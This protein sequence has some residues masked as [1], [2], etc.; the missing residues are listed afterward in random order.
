MLFPSNQLFLD[1]RQK[2]LESMQIIKQKVK[3]GKID[4]VIDDRNLHIKDLFSKE[5][6]LK[7]FNGL[8]VKLTE[9]GTWGKIEGL[10]G[11]SGKIKV[12]MEEPI[13]ADL[14]DNLVGS[15]VELHYTKNMMKKAATINKF[16]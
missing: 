8:R 14:L 9:T 4:K 10:F 6:D 11:K 5:T 15:Q 16:K 2:Y 7:I 13:E 1:E 3:V 12:R